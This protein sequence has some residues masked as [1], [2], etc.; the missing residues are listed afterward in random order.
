[1]P[2]VYSHERR[3]FR[4]D[5]D[6]LETFIS[7]QSEQRVLLAWLFVQVYPFPKGNLE[8]AVGSLPPD[9]NMPLYEVLPKHPKDPK[10]SAFTVVGHIISP[11][12]EPALREFF[13]QVARL[14]D[15]PVVP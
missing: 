8:L 10:G 4:V 14:C 5:G 3:T 11:E 13:T 1:M 12:E 15:R 6:V 7:G 2:L 9:M